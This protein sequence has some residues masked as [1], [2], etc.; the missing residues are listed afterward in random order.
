MTKYRKI[1]DLRA[2]IRNLRERQY[3]WVDVCVL[4]DIL[5]KNGNPNTGLAEDIGY[6]TVKVH[7]IE[8]PYTPIDPAVRERL[9]LAPICP[10]CLRPFRSAEHGLHRQQ[11]QPVYMEWWKKQSRRS[12]RGWIE[13]LHRNYS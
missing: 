2:N 3:K 9:R 6:K 5:T 8:R 7:G 11:E 12:K 13:M 10:E 4:L 1:E